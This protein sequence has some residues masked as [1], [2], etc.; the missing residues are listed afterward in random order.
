MGAQPANTGLWLPNQT[1]P[2]LDTIKSLNIIATN[3]KNYITIPHIACI[4]RN[5]G[6]F[7]NSNIFDTLVFPKI[8]L[9]K[10]IQKLKLI[11]KTF[12]LCTFV[13]PRYTDTVCKL[14]PYI[15]NLYYN[16]KLLLLLRL[17]YNIHKR[18]RAHSRALTA[19]LNPYI[20]NLLLYT[21]LKLSLI[22]I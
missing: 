21:I 10:E 6:T 4:T 20:L 16:L 7:Q 2:A 19:K 14:N 22:H 15:S 8:I 5:N 11:S 17:L 13:K 18:A 1:R 12:I 9:N 3:L